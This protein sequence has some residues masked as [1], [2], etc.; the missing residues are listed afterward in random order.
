MEKLQL[1]KCK[2]LLLGILVAWLNHMRVQQQT[3]YMLPEK[4]PSVTTAVLDI[5]IFG[6]S[7]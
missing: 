7:S 6:I 2:E 5:L 3:L 1:L 4:W